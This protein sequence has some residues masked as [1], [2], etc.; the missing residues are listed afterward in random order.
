MPNKPAV[1]AI[2]PLIN[3][4]GKLTNPDG[5]NVTNG[6]Y[7][8]VF[9]IYNVSSAGSAIWTETQPTVSVTDGIFQVSLGSVTAL[10]GSVDFNTSPLYLGVKVN[11]DLE[12]TPRI[13]F[14]AAPFAFNSDK[15]NGLSSAAFGQLTSSQTWTG[16]NT[17]QPTTNITSAIIKQTSA[18]SPSSD[19]FNVQT[20]NGTSILQVTGPV[21]NEAAVTLNSVGVTR[22]LTL[23]S[24]S[25]T[26][27]LGANTTTLQKS[28]TSFTFDLNNA[29]NSTL[30]ITNAAA[31]VA[32]L[33]V[34]GNITTTG[35]IG[36]AGSTTFTGA[37]GTFSSSLAANGGITLAANQNISTTSGNLTVSTVT[38]GTLALNSAGA[39]NLTGAAGSTLSTTGTGSNLILRSGAT[40]AN[41]GL[42]VDTNAVA[43][44]SGGLTLT[45][46]NA[47]A[48]VSGA[49]NISTGNGTTA[50]GI[51]ALLTG[52]ASSGTAG[53][54]TFD[55][56]T[57]SSG[58]GSILIGNASRTQTVTLG[59]NTSATTVNIESGSG[60]I[61]L[62][63]SAG[64][65]VVF[66][67]GAGSNLQ[68]TASAVPTVDQLA[69]SNVGQGVINAGVNGLSINYVGGS[70][71]IESAG[72]RI[73]LTPGGS[74]GGTWSGLRIVAN[75]TGAVSGVTEYGV[76]IEGP[77]TPGV[78]T[79]T[80][81]YIGT[82]WD[83]GL[84]VQSGGLNLAGYTS[85]G[86]PADPPAPATDNLRVYAK[87]VS[88]RMLLK[89][90]GPSGLDSPLQP[91]LFG[92]NVVMFSTTSG[93]TVTGG[94]GTLW[95]KGS[96]A[97]TV[98]TPTPAT[99]VPAITNQV[100]RTR[101]QNV[102]TTT[103][104][105][106]GIRA[107]SADAF[108][109]WS[110]NSAGLGGYFFT[111]RFDLDS[112]P[113]ANIRIF[114]GLSANASEAVISDVVNNN[115]VGLWHDTTDSA[116]TLNLVTR[117]AA[118]TKTPIALSNA[119]AAGNSYDWYMFMKPNDTTVYYRLDDIV[120]GVSYEGN[121]STNLPANTAFMA[122]QVE[123]SNGTANI[124][125]GGTAIGINRIYIESDH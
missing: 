9:S 75:G 58:N 70:A 69:I 38:S 4:Q 3:F 96:S 59:N 79:E 61:N 45:T 33:S 89:I 64:N 80:G 30:S 29:S 102:V 110:G 72:A 31:G 50:T 97:G 109:F 120:N 107:N 113:A 37:G 43:S 117:G 74:S 35:T 73:D 11:A 124:A 32:S 78:G 48:G 121:T 20:A 8:V 87:K 95:A 28:G 19:I 54:I 77:T 111:T 23:D 106:M 14:T 36:S 46:G 84:D 10:P 119:L 52:A 56:G 83:T 68:L 55:V 88:G 115:T 22:N 90:K 66:S 108:Q 40:T 7:S 122:P 27:V 82:G 57:S 116:T 42:I 60:N 15:L 125:V 101:H 123:M 6:S 112:Y 47:A 67:Q 63:P 91:A 92:N 85:G 103:N 2:N 93:A 39:L 5:T 98:S 76:K 44:G 51:I 18:A 71:P 1:A 65:H 24:G 13:L 86:N 41:T 16:T 25:G 104:Q 53:N 26:I 62:S 100:H 94:F 49:N 81:M 34:E 114:A 118:T 12:M 21:A 17:L 99:T 105:A